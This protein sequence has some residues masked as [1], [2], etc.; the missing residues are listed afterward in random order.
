MSERTL[1][2]RAVYAARPTVHV[3]GDV[4]PRLASLLVGMELVEHEDGLGTLELRGEERR[5]AGGEARP[6]S[7]SRTSRR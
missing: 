4:N 7:P 6:A 5:S 3:N 2:S 1:S